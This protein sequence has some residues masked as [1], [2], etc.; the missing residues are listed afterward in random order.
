MGSNVRQKIDALLKQRIL[1][2]DGGMG[3]MIQDYKLEEQD[4]RGERFAD[5]HSDLKGNNDLLVL[6]QPKLIKDIHSQYLEAG[7]DI[8]E[9]NTF[10]ATTIAM[11]D[12]D[13]ESLSE[14][15]NFAAA[16]LAREAA[17]E[18]TAKTPEK[19]RFVAG[20]LGPTNRTCSISPDVNDPGYRNVS[21]DE[22][23]EAYSES[24]RALIKGGSDLILIETIF[25]TLNAKA[26]A[27]AVESVFEEVGITLPVMISG[28]ITDASGRT[29]SGQTTEA[30]Y[31]ALRHVKPISFGLNCALGPDELREYVGEMSR[32]S[33]SYVSAHPNAG[34]PNAFGEYDLS[35]EDMAEH[36]KEWAESGFLNLIGGCCGTTPEHIRQMAEAVEGVTPR[37]LPDLPVSCRLSG[38]EPLTIAKE[39]LFVNVGERTNVT[40]SARFK[41]LI[42][43][44]L[45]DEALSVAREQVENGAQIIDINMD[46]G[47][48]DAEACMVKFLNLCASEPEISKV[49]VMVDSS[50]WEVI[51]A[52]L[53]CIQGKGVVNSI[54]LKEG[55]EKFVE[56]AK[57]VRR[58]GA[59]VIV[60]AFDEV[61]Q[62]DTRE[63]KV[64]ICTNAYNILVDEVGFPPEDIIFDPNIFAVATGIEEHNNYAVDFIEAVGDIKRDLPHAMISGGV[65][66]VSFSFR[67]NNYVREAIHAVFLYH[68]FKNG[69]D[70]GIVNAGQLEIYDNVPEDLRDAVEDVVLNRRDDSTERLLDMATEYLERAVGKVEDKSALEWRTWPVEKRLEHSLVKGITDFIVEDTEEAR[71][72]STRPIEVIEGPLM[73]GMNVVGDLFGAGKMFLPQVVK[74]ARVMKQAVAHLEPFIN[75]SKE[76]GASNGKI[77]LATV[78]GDVH[79]IGKN[80]VGVVLQCNNYDIIDLGV[81]VSCEKILKVAKEEN[82]DII[83]LSGLIT[84]SLDEMVHVAKEM[85]RQ[86]FKLPLLI[87]G[88]TTS[89]A[90][91]AVK[92]EQNYSEPV[93]YVNNASRAVGVCTSLLS[94]ELKPAFVEKLDLDYERVRDQ[95]NRKKPR[96]KPVTLEQA[97]AN[98]VAIDWDAY[99]P[100]APAKPGVHVLNDFDVATLRNYID[101]TPFFM[102]WSLVG[103]YPAILD[104]EEVGEEAKRLFKDANELL[105]RVEKE[106]LLEARGMCAMFP[107]NSVGDDIEV[108][109]DE[110]RTEVL[111]VL[112]NLRQQT[113]KPK[114]FNYCLSDYIAPKESGKADW[115]GGFAVTGGIGERELADEYK[116][117]GDDYN[118]IMI[119]AVADRLAEAFA[120]YLHQ[121]VRKDIWGYA[122]DEDLSNDD[123]IR[124]KYQGIRP[125]PG[126]PACPEHTEKGT[127]WELMDVEKTIDMSLTSSYAMWP[128]ASVSGMYF[129]HPDSRYFAIAQIQ[130]DQVDSYA[131]RKGWNMLEAEKWLGPNIN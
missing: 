115:I 46:E 21:F 69:M 131:D 111:K 114:G 121:E 82:V 125:A 8:L 63:R 76:V 101:W 113:E 2:I 64:E 38:L 117:N 31:N 42:K 107:A 47:M 58:Y 91:T 1:L 27:F 110:S 118:A 120:E 74:S 37:Q 100:P 17:D 72:N 106:K 3:T 41:R 112:H 124:E 48:L 128:G 94:E 108:Y 14:E 122:P 19:P 95:H 22:L 66:N 102:T 35:P 105:D 5:W 34:L 73:D 68:C 20:V 56:Q 126:Y 70:M 53:K 87:G 130:Q 96:T 25:D 11:A 75:A 77:L 50:K 30:F 52:G 10:N 61:G 32:I 78:K 54:S 4:Y 9:T 45:Y 6:T 99:T 67:G 119:Q 60:M 62:A 71:V 36:V 39:S 109:T 86:G 129:S 97:R 44:E 59:A 7:A 43:E 104:H 12:Y 116:A 28:T 24:T 93:V 40:G 88:A 15:I 127:L 57:L 80:I 51:E 98:K 90:H 83:G 49:P 79:D 92:I 123:L 18:W 55:K 89:K 16:K 29:L 85:E 65:S 84:P 13:M 33:E 23:V 26:C 103:K 81:M